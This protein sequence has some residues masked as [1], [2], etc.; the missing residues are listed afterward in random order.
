[1]KLQRRE[2]LQG[3]GAAAVAAL[4]MSKLALATTTKYNSVASNAL[5]P[6]HDDMQTGSTSLG[7]SAFYKIKPTQLQKLHMAAKINLYVAQQRDNGNLTKYHDQVVAALEANY[8]TGLED[9]V[10]AGYKTANSWGAAYPQAKLQNSL[11]RVT[12]SVREA[13]ASLIKLHGIG[14]VPTAMAQ[15]I[16][17]DAMHEPMTL[18]RFIVDCGLFAGA[19]MMAPIMPEAVV[20][21][22]SGVLV[23]AAAQTI[24][25]DLTGQ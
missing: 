24:Y 11:N 15:M 18:P 16:Q 9:Q 19:V 4:P 3:I 17:Q 2:V 8:N 23:A 1:M 21:M 14:H 22:G 10:A 5:G 6:Y 7:N 12:P 25:L 13:T 20:I